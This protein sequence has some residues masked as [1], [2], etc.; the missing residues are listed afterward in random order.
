MLVGSAERLSL[1]CQGLQCFGCCVSGTRKTPLK[2]FNKLQICR[3]LA[4]RAIQRLLVSSSVTVGFQRLAKAPNTR[5]LANLLDTRDVR[6]D[7]C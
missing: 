6:P 7:L 3:G 5:Q 2:S 4:L 1:V